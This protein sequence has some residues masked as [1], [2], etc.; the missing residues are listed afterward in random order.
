MFELSELQHCELHSPANYPHSVFLTFWYVSVDLEP[1]FGFG[2]SAPSSIIEASIAS[3]IASFS[4]SRRGL[5]PI[6]LGPGAFFGLFALGGVFDRSESSCN[7]GSPS[8]SSSS[9]SGLGRFFVVFNVVCDIFFGAAFG[10]PAFFGAGLGFG[11]ALGLAAAL[12]FALAFYAP[13]KSIDSVGVMTLKT[14]T[15]VGAKSS[16]TSPSS[17]TESDM[18]ESMLGTV[19]FT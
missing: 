8:E 13:S 7:E 15:V 17:N 1:F 18:R 2:S 12:G 19:Y 6:F 11:S 14:V 9:V 4:T 16:E 5:A 3:A 10:A